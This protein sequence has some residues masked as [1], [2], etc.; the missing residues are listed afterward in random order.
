MVKII[1][2]NET[3]HYPYL[4]LLPASQASHFHFIEKA[5]NVKLFIINRRH[6]LLLELPT[7]SPKYQKLNSQQAFLL[8]FF[9][10]FKY[11]NSQR[12]SFNFLCSVGV[13]REH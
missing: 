2:A 12:F 10:N 9:L 6:L 1:L 4:H 5:K 3:T 7:H 11:F 8:N 13:K